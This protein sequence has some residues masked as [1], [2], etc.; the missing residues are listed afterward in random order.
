MQPRVTTGTHG[1]EEF[2]CVVTPPRHMAHEWLVSR[3]DNLDPHARS[4]AVRV[5]QL[6]RLPAVVQPAE[7]LAHVSEACFQ[8]V[9]RLGMRLRLVEAQ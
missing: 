4:G 5:Q 2:V 3:Q 7:L 8:R 9:P 1:R 6:T